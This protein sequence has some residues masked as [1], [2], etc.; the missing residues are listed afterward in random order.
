MDV[1]LRS[2]IRKL[3]VLALA[4]T[5]LG[6][7]YLVHGGGGSSPGRLVGKPVHE[8]K[9]TLGDMILAANTAQ[10]IHLRFQGLTSGTVDANHANEIPLDSLSFGVARQISG[11]PGSE[12]NGGRPS[13]SEI[14]VN[15]QADKYS[16][17]LLNL[18]LRGQP[19]SGSNPTA[20]LYLTNLT[21]PGGAPFDYMKIDLQQVLISQYSLSS[22][23]TENP[24]ESF[25]LNIG[26]VITFTTHYP[27]GTAQTVTYNIPQNI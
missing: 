22:G 15:H 4:V 3:L 27:A 18:A 6:A 8:K 11:G 26:G 12:R 25:S 17:G 23:S 21:G 9:L 1:A 19:T 5:C 7:G 16:A 24:T 10:G 14:T 20:T 13:I 2:S